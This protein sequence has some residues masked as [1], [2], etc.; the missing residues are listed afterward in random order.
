MARPWYELQAN[1]RL[2]RYSWKRN[3]YWLTMDTITQFELV[4]LNREVKVVI[5]K[6]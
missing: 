1:T 6:D 3:Q 4:L 2:A 5:E